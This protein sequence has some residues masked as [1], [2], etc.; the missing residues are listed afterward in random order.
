MM[1][2]ETPR[3]VDNRCSSASSSSNFDHDSQ[4]SNH[5]TTRG[6]FTHTNSRSGGGGRS[7]RMPSGTK[8]NSRTTELIY[9]TQGALIQLTGPVKG[10]VGNFPSNKNST[11][12]RANGSI[13]GGGLFS[14]EFNG[15]ELG[16]LPEFD[17]V[18]D[19]VPEEMSI[20]SKNSRDT[21]DDPGMLRRL[22]SSISEFAAV[23]AAG[24]GSNRYSSQ[25][26]GTSTGESAQGAGGTGSFVINYPKS[27]VSSSPT[28]NSET[29]DSTLTPAVTDRTASNRKSPSNAAS[30]N[31]RLSTGSSHSTVFGAN[32]DL[33]SDDEEDERRQPSELRNGVEE[34]INE[35]TF[36]NLSGHHNPFL[37]DIRYVH[38][39]YDNGELTVGETA[40]RNQPPGISCSNPIRSSTSYVGG[41]HR[42]CSDS[43]NLSNS[44][45]SFD[46]GADRR[47][48]SLDIDFTE[49]FFSEPPKSVTSSNSGS[50]NMDRKEQL[51][52][53]IEQC[54][55]M[56]KLNQHDEK[57][58]DKFGHQLVKLRYLLLEEDDSKHEQHVKKVNGHKFV[59]SATRATSRSV[60]EHCKQLLLGLVHSWYECLNCGFKAHDRCLDAVGRVCPAVRLEQSK[61]YFWNIC[62]SSGLAKQNFR[63]AE[64]KCLI[65]G[66]S[67]TCNIGGS[68]SSLSSVKSAAAVTGGG[69][70]LL[71]DYSGLYYC[72]NCHWNDLMVIP[73]RVVFNW[74]FRPYRVSRYWHAYLQMVY[75]KAIVNISDLNPSLYNHIEELG[76][77]NN[78]RKDILKMKSYFVGCRNASSKRLLLLLENRQ[79]F[80][81]NSHMFSLK[82]LVDIENKSL[83]TTFQKIYDLF[84]NHIRRDCEICKNR[85][86]ICELCDSGA[87]I[88]PFDDNVHVCPTCESTYHERC[89]ENY[90][91]Q[92]CPRCSRRRQRKSTVNTIVSEN[93]LDETN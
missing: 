28:R 53:A 71:C 18:S 66:N 26:E 3:Y 43:F 72:G 36:E 55:R 7:G 11:P 90:R 51:T 46:L 57:L 16:G 60:C 87:V 4:T 62:T 14:S 89:Y 85:G 59:L 9:E 64:C 23:F 47:R 17:N 30:K 73:A 2:F 83:L 38:D 49:G 91:K 31:I 27:S 22:S 69:E 86:F 77:V 79:H 20:A 33:G 8:S 41:M 39:F 65:G 56:L 80:V 82:D 70:A 25:E 63:C 10:L 1:Q 54:K 48:C 84:S 40:R 68:S 12:F 42:H 34:N 19:F 29:V 5:R 52:Q 50:I 93:E 45:S 13:V 76:T 35:E 88:F 44:F 61:D 67:V 37:R 6:S 92:E 21:D 74:D 78:M 32:F 15:T 24:S 81:E 58:K 75:R